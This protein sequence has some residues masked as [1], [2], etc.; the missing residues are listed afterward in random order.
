MDYNY[1]YIYF[2][3]SAKNEF[4]MSSKILPKDEQSILQRQIEQI[5]RELNTKNGEIEMLE[6]KIFDLQFSESL[7]M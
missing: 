1:L 7:L 5:G 4:Q 2:I 3:F 6:K